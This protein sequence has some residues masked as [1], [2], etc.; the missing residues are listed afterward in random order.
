MK[1]LKKSV[2]ILLTLTM[3]FGILTIIPFEASAASG[4]SYIY[5]S[6]DSTNQRVVDSTKTCSNYSTIGTQKDLTIGNGKWYVVNGD[7]SISNRITVTGTANIILLSGTL[8]CKDGIRLS[9]GNTLNIYPG[10][11]GSGTLEAKITGTDYANIGGNENETC[12]TLNFYGGTLNAKNRGKWTY[13][14]AIGGGEKGG[15]G[16]LNFYGGKVT[17]TNHGIASARNATGAAIGSGGFEENKAPAGCINIYGGEIEASCYRYSTAAGI[18]GGEES[19]C[20]PINILGGKVTAKGSEGAGIGTGQEGISD[21]ITIRY[22][23][24]D[25]EGDLGAAIGSGEECNAGKIIIE[26][27]SVTADV[28]VDGDGKGNEGA[29]IGGNSGSSTYIKIDKSIVSAY[30]SK[31]G[32]GIG[33][34][35][36][37]S[38]GVIEITDSNI[39]AC[40][41]LG[42]AAIGGGDE[43]G[44]DSITIKGSYVVATTASEI[45]TQEKRFSAVTATNSIRSHCFW[46][47][48]RLQPSKPHFM[49]PERLQLC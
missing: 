44:C 17:V 11:N 19:K 48:I 18:G 28:Q 4:I 33:G 13:A 36:E 14:A 23:N 42:G 32:A 2:S 35:D 8:T 30:A 6:W 24:I 45:N 15:A 5:R 20:P 26:S 40:S 39:F 41:G 3:M 27:S 9:Q 25:A 12:G 31:Y 46:R 10:Q 29:A 7:A 22:A 37:G 38:G 21:T 16:N 1:L 43:K 49:L 47:R 34:G